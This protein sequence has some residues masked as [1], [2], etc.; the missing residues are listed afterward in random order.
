MLSKPFSPAILV[1]AAGQSLRFGG[2][3]V[4]APVA[5]APM[6]VETLEQLPPLP[7]FVATGIHHELIVET[8]TDSGLSRHIDWLP[9][10]TAKDGLGHTISESVKRL[11]QQ[12]IFSHLLIVLADQVA[13]TKADFTA[14]LR[15]AEAEPEKLICC[16]FDDQVSVPAIFPNQYFDQLSQLSGD[17]GAKALLQQ[18]Q[19]NLISL[20]LERARVDI[21]TRLELQAWQQRLTKQPLSETT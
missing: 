15:R 1:L 12:Q 13:V 18:N 16:Q 6:F 21:D 4:V 17:K 8:Y 3:K 20:K 19:S 9:C 2:V 11:R 7:T 10:T 14:M 5:S